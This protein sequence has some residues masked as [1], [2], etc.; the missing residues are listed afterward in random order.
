MTIRK[1]LAL[2]SLFPLAIAMVAGIYV[3]NKG[4]QI[5][6]HRHA[7][8]FANSLAQDVFDLNFLTDRYIIYRERQIKTQWEAKYGAIGK[9]LAG[10]TPADKSE[11]I[12]LEKLRTTHRET[13]NIFVRLTRDIEHPDAT[14]NVEQ[15]E[16]RRERLVGVLLIKGRDMFATARRLADDHSESLGVIRDSFNRTIIFLFFFLAVVISTISALSSRRIITAIDRL[17]RGTEVVAAGNLD[18][19]VEQ[20]ADDELGRLADAFNGMTVRLK[21]S[22]A[23]LQTTLNALRGEV[24]VRKRA[25]E[26]ARR[27]NDELARAIEELQHEMSERLKTGEELREKERLLILQGR[28]AAMGEMIG[29]IAHQWRQPLNLLGLLIQE[30]PMHHETGKLNG[31]H[32]ESQ[33]GKAMQVINHMSQTIDDFM[34]FF[35]P[36]KEKVPFKACD[37][38]AGVVSL[39]QDSFARFGIVI[40]TRAESDPYIDGYPNEFSQVLI[41]IL[42]NAKDVV[43]ERKT[44]NPRVE[45]TTATENGKV[46]VTIADNAGGIHESIMDK[47]F[48]PY[49]TTRGPDKGTGIGLFMSKNII[50]K[51][52]NGTLTARNTGDGAEFRIEV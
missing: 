41:N 15:L 16:E 34:N 52:M 38:V 12:L 13:G 3:S 36:D 11:R 37:S 50:E 21:A 51:N 22:S 19:R 23:E 4:K 29:N 43:E 48:D 9:R 18:H 33:V 47:I 28:Q 7:R 26:G 46:V 35:R 30:L 39:V 8:E 45:I 20:L 10:L 17:R 27:L 31:E 5:E 49:F 24:V 25:E 42:L 32:L 2:I 44:V 40:D 1:R 14:G 6:A